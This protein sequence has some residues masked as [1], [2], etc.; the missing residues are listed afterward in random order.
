MTGLSSASSAPAAPAARPDS[1][2][3][4]DGAR[5]RYRIDGPVGAPLLMLSNSLGTSLDMWDVQLPEFLRR[6]R[7]LRYDSRGHGRSE[8]TPG[9]YSI[10]RLAR[11]VLGLFDEL[12]IGRADFCGLSMGGMV[13]MWLGIHAPQRIGRLVLCNTAPRIG[14]AERWSARID[15]VNKGGMNVIADALL[16]LWFTRRFRDA[17]PDTVQ[18]MR[19]MLVVTPAAGYVASCAAVRDMDQWDALTRI[20]NQTLIVSGKNDAVTTPADNRRMAG[21]IPGSTLVELDA[22]HISNVE[23]AERF[24]AEVLAF[25]DR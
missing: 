17:S 24:T 13:G 2:A 5:I 18:R 1:F 9:P 12:R 14:T 4:V 8:V 16:D 10:E 23:A 20:E 3:V 11:D 7:V 6:F 25:L 19:T 22:A 15:A 21:L